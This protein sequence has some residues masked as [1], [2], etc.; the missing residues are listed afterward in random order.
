MRMESVKIASVPGFNFFFYWFKTVQSK[1]CVGPLFFQCTSCDETN[2]HSL[3][4][5]EWDTNGTCECAT[6]TQFA[7][8]NE[9]CADCDETW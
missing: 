7:I 2:E 5:A 9:A 1:T 8:Y 6:A 4:K 3:I